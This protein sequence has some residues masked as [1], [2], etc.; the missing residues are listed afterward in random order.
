MERA[1]PADAQPTSQEPHCLV[2]A[3]ESR[4]PG[5]RLPVLLLQAREGPR[6]LPPRAAVP[7]RARAGGL[8]REHHA[9][10][11]LWQR[12]LHAHPQLPVPRGRR[13]VPAV[14]PAARLLASKVRTPARAARQKL[15]APQGR[16]APRLPASSVRLPIC[17][18]RHELPAQQGRRAQRGGTEAC[19]PMVMLAPACVHTPDWQLLA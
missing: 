13:R 7:E 16:S 1:T 15:L 3:L 12:A 4:V 14:Q 8:H 6:L 17:G 9:E 11:V 18:L 5:T 2:L 10:L 19:A